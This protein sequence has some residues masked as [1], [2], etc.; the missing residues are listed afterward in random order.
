LIFDASATMA[1]ATDRH[2]VL[3]RLD[4]PRMPVFEAHLASCAHVSSAIRIAPLEW[5]SASANLLQSIED[6]TRPEDQSSF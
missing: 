6:I 5:F 3:E 1:F 2:L 4:W